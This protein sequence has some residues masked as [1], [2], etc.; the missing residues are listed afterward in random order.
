MTGQNRQLTALF[1]VFGT[2][3]LMLLRHGYIAPLFQRERA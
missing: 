2:I 3:I 1:C